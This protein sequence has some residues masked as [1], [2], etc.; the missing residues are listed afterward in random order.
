[1][2]AEYPSQFVLFGTVEAAKAKADPDGP[3]LKDS[4]LVAEVVY[5]GLKEPT[6][7]DFLG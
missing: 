7:M 4:N 6:A 1:L 5:K 3:T 2:N